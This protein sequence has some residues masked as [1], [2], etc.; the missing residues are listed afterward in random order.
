MFALSQLAEVVHLTESVQMP[1]GVWIAAVATV[2][3]T[4][5]ASIGFAVYAIW[6]H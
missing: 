2:A 6:F 1:L 5:W 3:A 4:G